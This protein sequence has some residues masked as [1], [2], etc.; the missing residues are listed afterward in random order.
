[1]ADSF[2]NPSGL[3]IARDPDAFREIYEC[4]HRRIY[5]LAWRMCGNATQA[6]DLTQDVFVRLWDSWGS[7]RGESAFATWLHRLAVNVI[8]SALVRERK[9]DGWLEYGAEA[10]QGVT[11]SEFDAIATQIDLD[12]ALAMLP[13]GAR[14]ILLLYTVDGC[15]YRDIATLL[16]VDIGTVKSQLHR[17]RR[18]LSE[19]F[20][21]N[22]HEP[23]M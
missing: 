18:L 21:V 3:P 1:M 23:S 9:V 22:R 14:T 13:H 12:R 10:E 5:A 15:G 17:A 6:E 4:H 16:G 8:W 19:S 7:F 2:A 11:D 20:P